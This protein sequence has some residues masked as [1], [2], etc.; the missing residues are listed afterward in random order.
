M[1]AYA[2][3]IPRYLSLRL[4][5]LETWDAVFAPYCLEG[6]DGPQ[7]I[8]SGQTQTPEELC[9]IGVQYEADFV[10]GGQLVVSGSEAEILLLIVEVKSGQ[11]IARTVFG[12]LHQ[13][14]ALFTQLLAIVMEAVAPLQETPPL[15]CDDLSP[16]WEATAPF[17]A[18][19]DR[20]LA[21][22]IGEQ[23]SQAEVFE[24]FFAAVEGDPAWEEGAEQLIGTAL[25]YGLQEPDA[26]GV[27]VQVLERLVQVRP[28]MHKA[29]EALGYLYHA[30]GR[31]DEVVRV[32]EHALALAPQ[33]FHSHHRLSSA[34]RQTRRFAEAEALLR[35][36]LEQDADN[37]PLLNELGVV[38]GECDRHEE[39]AHCFR[40]LVELSPISGA[41][42]ANLGVTL[43]RLGRFD[44]AE[45]AFQQGMRALD[46]HWN[47]YVNYA[48]L[49]EEQARHLDWV[50]VLFEG[51]RAL[52]DAPEERIDL[53]TRLVD[54]VHAWTGDEPPPPKVNAKGRGWLIGLL[55]SLV[56][57]L[58]EHQSS[59]VVLSELYRLD[60]RPQLA[61]N[62]L[63]RVAESDPDN[64]WLK[65][66]INSIKSS[67][68]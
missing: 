40:R 60:G 3:Q 20:L 7:L 30:D 64:I 25:D 46:P 11:E 21:A 63:L 19:L 56:E 52:A 57:M 62:C 45:E 54:G 18:A 32:M 16:R 1:G 31:T 35:R 39:S 4:E 23:V 48:E 10:I 8:V 49:L 13:C 59:W 6:E 33:A 50:H 44:E 14:R 47:V 55:E 27:G 65:I 5:A 9:E 37:I 43:Q 34:Y 42:H 36:G 66:H 12:S 24:G 2:R 28:Q 58:P 68:P 67:L 41:F 38:L 26:A 15:T 22:E 17:L 53:A 51:V 29:W 61:L